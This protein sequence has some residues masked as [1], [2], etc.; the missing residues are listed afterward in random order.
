MAFECFTVLG[1]LWQSADLGYGKMCGNDR[2]GNP[3]IVQHMRYRES[4]RL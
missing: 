4:R 2:S 3:V 1:K